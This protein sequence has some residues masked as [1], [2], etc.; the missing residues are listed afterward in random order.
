MCG[1]GIITGLAICYSIFRVSIKLREGCWIAKECLISIVCIF[2]DRWITHRRFP[3][4]INDLDERW[5]TKALGRPVRAV[6]HDRKKENLPLD[7]IGAGGAGTSRAFVRVEFSDGSAER[8]FVKLPA[9][10]LFERLFLT[11]FRV[12]NNELHFYESVRKYLPKDLTAEPL[13]SRM[14]STKFVLVLRDMSA[15]KEALFPTILD[16]Y[17]HARVKLVLDSL[18]RFHAENW[19]RPPPGIWVDEWSCSRTCPP[20]RKGRTR[21]PF[22]QVISST[23]LSVVLERFPT[24]LDPA[25]VRAYRKYMTNYSRVREFWS[26]GDLTMIH[27][28]CHIGNMGFYPS[29]GT[30]FFYDMQCVAAEHCMRDVSY[31]LLSCYNDGEL[32]DDVEEELLAF[33]LKR[34]NE[35]LRLDSTSEDAWLG[36]EDAYFHY[37]VHSFW[38]LTAFVISAGASELMDRAVGEVVLPR[39]SRRLLRIDA[40]GALDLVLGDFSRFAKGA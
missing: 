31:H 35:Y 15:T 20:T 36:Y 10:T 26:T 23:T 38:A 19:N 33:Y 6:V 24:S 14:E 7:Q 13:F 8:Y 16:A 25:I 30:M 3:E 17:P 21:P 32:D 11:V 28:D 37:R 29:R 4:K 9:A 2:L 39:L 12:Y 40:P 5:F 1:I 34:F 22:L 18:A 27:G